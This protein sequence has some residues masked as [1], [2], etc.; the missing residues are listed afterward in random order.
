[1]SEATLR[2]AQKCQKYPD[3]CPCQN[4]KCRHGVTWHETCSECG[5]FMVYV[6][7]PPMQ[8]WNAAIAMPSAP[9]GAGTVS[10]EQATSGV[11]VLPNDNEKKCFPSIVKG[12]EGYKCV[13]CEKEPTPRHL[14]INYVYTP[15]CEDCIAKLVASGQPPSAPAKE[16]APKDS[17]ATPTSGQEVAFHSLG[18]NE[19]D[20]LRVE[21]VPRS[22]RDVESGAV[23]APMLRA[24]LSPAARNI[25]DTA[26]PVV[27]PEAQ[28]EMR[29]GLEK[30][31]DHW[32]SEAKRVKE[33]ADKERSKSGHDSLMA[34]SVRF[35]MCADELSAI[36]EGKV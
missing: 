1:M 13:C 22:R 28:R 34:Q 32:K 12:C 26:M 31:R 4:A 36:L 20:S 14:K 19:G 5:R 8:L 16:T 24:G 18:A 29:K 25:P 33:L 9:Q 15:L 3:N 17:I 11:V 30:L 27:Q 35:W 10:E 6:T 2:A 7:L 21:D 23:G